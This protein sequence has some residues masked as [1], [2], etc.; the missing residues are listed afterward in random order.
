MKITSKLL[1]KEAELF[2]PYIASFV[3]SHM[4]K[5]YRGASQGPSQLC[6]LTSDLCVMHTSEVQ[7]NQATW[8]WK[9]VKNERVILVYLL[10]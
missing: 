6:F 7:K 9:C 2:S 1:W 5:L 4:V 10:M 8:F 3:A